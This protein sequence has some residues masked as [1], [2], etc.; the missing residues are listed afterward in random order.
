VISGEKRKKQMKNKVFAYVAIASTI[1]GGSA[2]VASNAFAQAPSA[3][4]TPAPAHARFGGQ[5]NER[6]PE[7]RKAMRALTNA[8][9]FLQSAATDFGGHKEKALD[10]T[11]NALAEVRAALAYDKH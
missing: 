7:L 6:H 5:K 3:P 8:Q 9:K 2:L 10:A 1:L 4:T 11:A